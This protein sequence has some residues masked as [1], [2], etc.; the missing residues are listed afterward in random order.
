MAA[1]GGPHRSDERRTPDPVGDRPLLGDDRGVS[2]VIGS[3]LLVAIVIALGAVSAA[4]FLGLPEQPHA[5]PDVVLEL[6]EGQFA[7]THVL[8]H[9]SGDSLGGTGR[10]EIRGI[11][12]PEALHDEELSAGEDESVIP[13][14][15]VD[16]TVRI[17]WQA[18]QD[19]GYIIWEGRPSSYL[20]PAP[21]EGCEWVDAETN[22]GTDPITIDGIVV[23]CDV[24]TEGDIDIQNGSTIVGEV[25]STQNNVDL[26][27]STVYGPVAADGDVDIDGTK[28][29]GSVV[30]TGD[31][32]VITDGSAIGGDVRAG[33]GTNVDVDGGSSIAGRVYLDGGSFS[34]SNAT[35]SGSGCGSYSPESWDS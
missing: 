2:P 30:A 31:D 18:D 15:P 8:R 16:E 33:A 21:D 29:S 34:C 11:A 13:V 17:V 24:I 35:I 25:N 19:T 6:E 23:T 26:D 5:S 14:V 10:T 27:E 28:V 20:D 32:V 22:G 3:V 7:P 9:E 1:D 12:D 4:V